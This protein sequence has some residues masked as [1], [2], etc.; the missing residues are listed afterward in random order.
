MG[1][2]R[3]KKR[4]RKK[5]GGGLI[6]FL[7]EMFNEPKTSSQL[8]TIQ[9]RTSGS[10]ITSDTTD[11]IVGIIADEVKYLYSNE[12]PNLFREIMSKPYLRK[13]VI[14]FLFLP[15]TAVEF[16]LGNSMKIQK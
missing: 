6:E 11:E 1:K 5:R 13:F 10:G 15:T 7:K 4:T 9:Q 2:R 3:L 8:T 14:D 16:D 12:S